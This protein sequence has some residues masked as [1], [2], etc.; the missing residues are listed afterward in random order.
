MQ[1]Q[2][3]LHHLQHVPLPPTLHRMRHE[4]VILHLIELHSLSSGL[5]TE[6]A[7]S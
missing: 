3:Q 7:H 2:E 6:D 4:G 1:R 5:L